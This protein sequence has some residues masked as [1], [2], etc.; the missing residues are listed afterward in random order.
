MNCMNCGDNTVGKRKDKRYHNPGTN[1]LRPL[2]APTGSQCS[3][4]SPSDASNHASSSNAANSGL[5]VKTK[6]P[7]ICTQWFC[8]PKQLPVEASTFRGVF[9][10]FVTWKI[11][12]DKRL[13]GCIG[14]FS[15]LNLHHGL[16]EYSISSAFKDSR[17][18]SVTADEIPKLHCSVS[19]LTDFEDA[20]HCL[21]WEI[22]VN[23]IRIEFHNDRG[24][25]KT[26]TYLPEV[27]KEQGWSKVETIDSLLRKGG[28]KGHISNE[29]RHR[30]KLT[31]YRSEKITVS[32]DEYVEARNRGHMQA[33]HSVMS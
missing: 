13:R 25:R 2:R 18:H 7:I 11:G 15:A 14:T 1:V 5:H 32:Y 17:F 30:I 31:R 16:K 33:C 12:K 21:D 29:I 27:A 6:A 8:F 9:P 4:S 20:K 26:A 22:G 28:F 19:I 24:H 10:L 23:G 3:C